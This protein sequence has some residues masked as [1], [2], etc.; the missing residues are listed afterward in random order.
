MRTVVI[1]GSS[2]GIGKAAAELLHRTRPDTRLLLVGRN[3]AKTRAA[4][5]ALGAEHF[6]ADFADLSQV[7]TL[8]DALLATTD[9][10]DVL[11]NNAGGVFDGP[12]I[13]ADGFEQ[14]WQ[15]NVVAPWLLTNLL[16]AHLRAARANVVATSS[17]AASLFSRFD[18]ADPDSRENFSDTRAY[19]NAKLGDAMMSAELAARFP[20]LNPVSFHPG[21]IA[22]NFAQ[23]SSWAGKPFYSFLDRTGLAGPEGGGKRLAYFIEGTAGVHFE[24]GKH[25]LRPGVRGPLKGPAYAP[26]VFRQLDENLGLDW[27]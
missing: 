21:V 27:D 16:R 6:T 20:E 2:D 15:V 17:I 7:R 14:T 10:I 5:E 4:A 12:E 23:D 25:Y 1:T 19:G 8:A 3:P 24:R 13:T 18:A 26:E 9:R 22:T 11:A